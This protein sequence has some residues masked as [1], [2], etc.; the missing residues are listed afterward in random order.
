MISL[1]RWHAIAV[2]AAS[3]GGTLGDLASVNRGKTCQRHKERG[4]RWEDER[5]VGLYRAGSGSRV[6][7]SER[8]ERC[9]EWA[10]CAL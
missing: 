2:L 10:M 6:G 1:A 7:G 8:N 9:G 5:R 3:G 4:R